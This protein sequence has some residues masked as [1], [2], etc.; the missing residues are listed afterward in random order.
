ME[1]IY[2]PN[3]K[4]LLTSLA[5]YSLIFVLGVVIILRSDLFAATYFAK[6]LGILGKPTSIQIIGVL[7]V[8]VMFLIFV[9]TIKLYY[10]NCLLIMNDQGFINKTNFTNIGLVLW[11][12]VKDVRFKKKK[13]NSMIFI[14]VEDD[15]KYFKR[16]KNP[17]I[18]LNI[19]TYKKTYKASFVVE[20]ANLTISGD[21]LF[22]IFK[23]YAKS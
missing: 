17:L 21:D 13:H 22:E 15:K 14:N 11:S 6:S 12:D 9:G 10:Q 3:K 20:T 1:I 4:K 2:K 19:L 8:A 18:K 16:I 5:V 23:K 7:S